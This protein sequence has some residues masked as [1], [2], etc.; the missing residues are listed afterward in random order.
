MAQARCGIVT[1]QTRGHRGIRKNSWIWPPYGRKRRRGSIEY[2]IVLY[3]R[4][5]TSEFAVRTASV[6]PG[7]LIRRLRPGIVSPKQI[8]KL[9]RTFGKLEGRW[10]ELAKFPPAE[11]AH[12]VSS[13]RIAV[14]GMF[15]CEDF[16]AIAAVL[17]DPEVGSP[18]GII[19]LFRHTT[20]AGHLVEGRDVRHLI[21]RWFRGPLPLGLVAAAVSCGRRGVL[22]PFGLRLEGCELPLEWVELAEAQLEFG[23]EVNHL[24]TNALASWDAAWPCSHCGDLMFELTAV[25]C[26]EGC[27][28]R[29][30]HRPHYE[31]ALRRRAA[32][33]RSAKRDRSEGKKRAKRR[34]TPKFPPLE[35]ATFW[36]IRAK[37]GNPIRDRQAPPRPLFPGA[38]CAPAAEAPPSRLR[39]A[40]NNPASP[41][42][43][44]P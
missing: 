29:E 32:G 40:K 6:V 25:Y 17:R 9:E 42:A 7:E 23:W 41:S 31:A 19:D 24:L 30:R 27:E 37:G 13:G 43:R 5:V 2:P 18:R 3:C 33:S 26:S 44:T 10:R 12:Y 4:R 16:A 8:N 22:R 38:P 39:M 34:Q 1:F 20:V 11:L 36:E 14:P 21:G 35:E 15:P 28:R